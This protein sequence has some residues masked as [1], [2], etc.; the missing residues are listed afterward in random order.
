MN[1]GIKTRIEREQ[2]IVKEII[3]FGDSNTYGLV[4]GSAQRF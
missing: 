1:K 2:D 4:P 3:C